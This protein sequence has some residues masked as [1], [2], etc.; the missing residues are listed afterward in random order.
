MELEL[1][2]KGM[3]CNHCKAAV[4]RGLA[5]LPGVTGVTVDLARGVALVEGDVDDEVLA[6][7]VVDLGY[8]VG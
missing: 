5:A 8:E 3:M 7:A 6:K 4:E 1:K 2:V